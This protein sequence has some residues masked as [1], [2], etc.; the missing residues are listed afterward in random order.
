MIP[1]KEC[2]MRRSRR[3]SFAKKKLFLVFLFLVIAVV[4][5]VFL[6]PKDGKKIVGKNTAV[7]KEIEQYYLAV[8]HFTDS[9][10]NLSLE[11]IKS[12]LVNPQNEEIYLGKNE[13]E[14]IKKLLKINDLSAQVKITEDNQIPALLAEKPN[15]FALIPFSQV[16]PS[17]KTLSIDGH[18]FWS[19][20]SLYP[21]KIKVKSSGEAFDPSKIFQLTTIG[22]VILGRHVAYKM[23]YYH[24]YTHPWLKLASLVSQGDLSFADLEVPLSDRTSPPDEGTSF[25]APQKSIAGLKLAGIDVVALANNHSTNF[26][27]AAFMDTLALL[28]KESIAYTGGGKDAQ[29]AYKPLI[30]EKKGLKIAFIDF[31]SIIGAINASSDSPGVAKLDIK[32][33]AKSDS[34]EDITRVK[35]IISEAKEQ[36]D[37]V[38]AQFHWGVEYEPDPI[39]SQIKV[40]HAAIDA[41][42]DLIVGTHPHIVQGMELY[43]DVP[44]LYSLGNFIFDQE[45]S[46]ETKQGV[47]A[48][49]FFYNKKLTA[50]KMTPY[51]IEDY[52][53]PNFAT[54]VQKNQILS[55]IFDASLSSD[56]KN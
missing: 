46:I 37:I 24:D 8:S 27:D 38:V 1:P 42:A 11:Q 49:N 32:P 47:V 3:K 36:A 39:P 25:I 35:Q 44:V 51:Q 18:Y 28:K 45:W 9:A 26:G 14:N 33:W 43:Q 19:D 34:E 6:W 41:G 12:R 40:A 52:N 30:L 13:K 56:Y 20:P 2:K 22:D 54:K 7:N 16:K 10:D 4:G 55:R 23:R 15:R 50:I 53:Q 48:E 29:E 31:N 21:L 17:L 5:L